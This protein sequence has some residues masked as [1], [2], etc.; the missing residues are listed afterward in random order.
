[1]YKNI[2]IL[3]W[4]TAFLVIFSC[5]TEKT[6]NETRKPNILLIMADD[7]GYECISTYGSN[8][9]QT[10]RLDQMAAEGVK[11]N[12]AYSQ[13]LC[14]PTRVKIMTGKSNVRNYEYFGY[15]NP[16]QK[17]FGNLLQ[18]AGYK[19]LIAGK[20]QLN[21]IYHDLPGN[22]DKT[23]PYQFGFDEYCL[24]QL[25]KNKQFGERFADP[26]IEQNEKEMRLMGQYGPDVFRDYIM[27]FM[28]RNQDS[29]FFIYYPMVLVHDPFVPTPDSEAWQDSTRRYETDT[30]YFADM[31]AYT[32]KIVGQLMDKLEEL[33][34]LENTL[35][36]FT[37]DNGTHPSIYTTMADGSLFRGGKGATIEAGNHVPFIAY[38][39]GKAIAGREVN[40][41]IEFSD[42]LPTLL[43][44]AEVQV[45]NFV[46]DGKSFLS[47]ITTPDFNVR[48]YVYQH[49][50]PRW[51]N[52]KD[53]LHYTFD[54]E[55][56]LYQDGRF[57]HTATD[58]REERSLDVQNLNEEAKERHRMLESELQK[59]IETLTQQK[60]I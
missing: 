17:T 33:S 59:N 52:W 9:Y 56:K 46:T 49:Y 53:S 5:K 22:Q 4:A 26:F 42:V 25:T 47:A 6:E 13:P 45:D 37:G 50:N 36:I 40:E 2:L 27:D 44:L 18:N 34:L 11:F 10:P 12:Q 38:W 58:P 55:Y 7:M 57:Y 60:S 54:Q 15:L 24:W 14:T 31:V 8:E 21:G 16:D 41:M 48:P 39:K 51:G 29:S 1:M 3:L 19:T 20:W 28:E 30:A 32:D 35:V 43:E 23:R